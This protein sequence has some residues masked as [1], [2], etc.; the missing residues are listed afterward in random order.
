MMVAYQDWK[1]GGFVGFEIMPEENTPCIASALR[2]SIINLGKVPKF[3]YQDNGKAFKSK[4]FIENGLSGLFTNLGIQPVY[5]KPYNAKAKPIERLFRELQDSCE[6][7]LLHI[8]ERVYQ[9]SR[10]S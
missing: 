10:H 1:S 8:Q 7:L 2:N 6:V 5:A 3:V 9:K 4:Y